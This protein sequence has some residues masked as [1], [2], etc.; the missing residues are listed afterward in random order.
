M[1][2]K[3]LQPHLIHVDLFIQSRNAV[4]LTGIGHQLEWLA[5]TLQRTYER[6]SIIEKHIVVGHPVDEQQGVRLKLDYL[7]KNHR[8]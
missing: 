3:K 8:D 1:S 4:G 5:P 6:N 2:I 7:I